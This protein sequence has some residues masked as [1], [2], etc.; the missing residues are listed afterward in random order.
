MWRLGYSE[1]FLRTTRKLTR[2][3]RALREALAGAVALL[4]EDPHNPHLKLDLLHGALEGLWAVR[5]TYKVRIVFV[6]HE[7]ERS[8]ILVDAGSHDEVY[9]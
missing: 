7:E 6:L 1:T 3:N 4:E 9:R 2:R 8:I 5:V